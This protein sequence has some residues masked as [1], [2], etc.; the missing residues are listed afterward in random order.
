MIALLA[1]LLRSKFADQAWSDALVDDSFADLA[2]AQRVF[3]A[4]NASIS[5]K[6]Q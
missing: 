3:G 2:A 4:V 5:L 6:K 1:S